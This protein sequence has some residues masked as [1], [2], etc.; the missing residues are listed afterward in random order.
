M[1]KQESL[2]W[3]DPQKIEVE[4]SKRP[5]HKEKNNSKFEE[6]LYSPEIGSKHFM[7]KKSNP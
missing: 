5:S 2:G 4:L 1:V 6:E 3:E 7:T